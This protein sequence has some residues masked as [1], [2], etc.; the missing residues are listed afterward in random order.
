MDTSRTVG[1]TVQQLEKEIEVAASNATATSEHATRM[2]IAEAR[3]N[4]QAQL[5]HNRAES[6]HR[7]A[8]T[9][10]HM[11]E[12]AA[13]LTTLTDQ[14]NRFKPVR[15]ADVSGSQEKLSSAVDERINLQSSRI[16]VVSESAH[17]AHKTTQ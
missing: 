16:D 9:K 17:E 7:D 5:E 15:V 12:I 8:D 4:F 1:S 2:V 10:K 14:L 6:Q 11:D 13:R 3:R